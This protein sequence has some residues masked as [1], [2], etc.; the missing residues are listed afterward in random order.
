M[1]P[2]T[3]GYDA[4]FD[5]RE[6]DVKARERQERRRAKDLLALNGPKRAAV[7]RRLILNTNLTDAEYRL[8]CLLSTKFG[9]QLENCFPS[10]RTILKY[11]PWSAAKLDRVIAGC[12]DKQF[13]RRVA[14]TRD[15]EGSFIEAPTDGQFISATGCQFLLPANKVQAD[16]WEGPRVWSNRLFAQRS[17]DS[18]K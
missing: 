10:R 3:A 11:L 13:L 7:Y 17:T 15:E 16:V 8:L 12:V 4:S 9:Q 18:R 5:E 2:D 6:S 1:I 14:L